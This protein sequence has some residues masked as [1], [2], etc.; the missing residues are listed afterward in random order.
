MGSV[1][2]AAWGGGRSVKP[3]VGSARTVAAFV[4]TVLAAASMW[5]RWALGGLFVAIACNASSGD[6]Y[7]PP[8]VTPSGEVVAEIGP[9]TLT[10]DEIENRVRRQNPMFQARLRQPGELERFVEA[11]VKG[12]LIAQEAY[13]RGLFDDPDVQQAMRQAAVRKLMQEKMKELDA[14]VEVSEDEVVAA[15]EERYDEFN[16]PEA[17]RLSALSRELESEKAR[18]RQKRAFREAAQ[19]VREGQKA[20]DMMAFDEEARQFTGEHDVD[21]TEVDRGFASREEVA[22]SYGE[23]AAKKLFDEMTVGDVAVFEHEDSVHL[24]RKTGRRRPIERSLE[25]VRR[26][27]VNKIKAKK[28]SEAVDA[29]VREIAE[30]RGISLEIQH[31]DAIDIGQRP[32]KA[33]TKDADAAPKSP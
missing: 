9:V 8:A 6:T 4:R 33:E 18:A 5:N 21:R 15:Y 12:E 31:V 26:S 2:A 19:R 7:P 24:V 11:E 13:D 27:L 20:G 10:T 3:P 29:F 14:Q 22:E 23:E 25:Q 28:R 1:A 17:V 30:R 32:A 16:R